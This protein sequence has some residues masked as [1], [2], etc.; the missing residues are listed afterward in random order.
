MRSNEPVNMKMGE[1]DG[2]RVLQSERF[3]GG[4][5]IS[6]LRSNFGSLKKYRCN[7]SV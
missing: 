6:G 1:A 5:Q 2:R 4:P 3:A 7:L